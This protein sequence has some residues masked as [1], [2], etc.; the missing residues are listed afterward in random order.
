VKIGMY[1]PHWSTAMDG[2]PPTWP[3]MVDAARTAE[4]VGLDSVWVIGHHY[5]RFDRG[6][7]W[8]LWD[9]WSVLAG[10]AASTTR[11][12]MGPLVSCTAYR[13][14]ALLAKAA[15]AVDEISAGR[16]ILGLGG[17]Y[18]DAEFRALGIP[19]DHRVARFSEAV[20]VIH[21]LL[22]GGTVDHE[23]E[24]YQIHDFAMGL[25]RTRES[26]PPILIGASE[27]RMMRL[28]ARYADLWNGWL[29]FSID[30][31]GDLRTMR[32]ALDDACVEEGRDPHTLGRTVTV[33]AT[34][35]GRTMSFGPYEMSPVGR[36]TGAIAE[37]LHGLEAEG[38]DHIQ[39][40][41]APATAEGIEA[42]APVLEDLGRAR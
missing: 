42:F 7:P 3:D 37:A 6:D 10:I 20:A 38:V 14:P 39:L 1:L 26:G 27:P 12:E 18:F 15:A 5:V 8:A 4:D 30:P 23:G 40:C 34:L 31:I 33:A 35:L 16:L 41:L 9:P 22:R 24:H 17:G 29:S 13:H 32:R 25:P 19:N 21:E 28:T 2:D 11:I 36:E